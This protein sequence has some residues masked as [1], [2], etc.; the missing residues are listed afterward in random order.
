VQSKTR[1]TTHA[2]ALRIFI[3][4]SIQE[5]HA[6]SSRAENSRFSRLSLHPDTAGALDRA[7]IEGVAQGAL[8]ILRLVNFQVAPAV[9]L[10]SPDAVR[11]ITEFWKGCGNTKFEN[12]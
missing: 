4:A 2:I 12:N 8:V 7:C 5:R 10:A 3:L 9:V 1:Q 11:P 6:K